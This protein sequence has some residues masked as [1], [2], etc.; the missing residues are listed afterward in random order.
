MWRRGRRHPDLRGGDGS[1]SW[2]RSQSR[3]PMS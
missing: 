2:P 1:S 3:A